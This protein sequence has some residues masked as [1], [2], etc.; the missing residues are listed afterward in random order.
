MITVCAFRLGML[1]A[2][3]R[4]HTGLGSEDGI[5]QGERRD[6]LSLKRA[7]IPAVEDTGTRKKVSLTSL[8]VGGN[9]IDVGAKSLAQGLKKHAGRRPFLKKGDLEQPSDVVAE[10]VS[11][12]TRSR[13]KNS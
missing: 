5:L 13:V 7:L 11:R 8:S 12:I 10:T 2:L 6:S 4:F 1:T 3:R 9:D